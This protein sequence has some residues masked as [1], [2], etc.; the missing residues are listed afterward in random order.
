MAVRSVENHTLVYKYLIINI[1]EDRTENAD[2]NVVGQHLSD[3]AR[4]LGCH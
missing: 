4:Y 3:A 2:R 1:A